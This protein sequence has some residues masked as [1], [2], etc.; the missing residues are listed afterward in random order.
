MLE[1]F[2][3][4]LQRRLKEETEKQ[5]NLNPEINLSLNLVLGLISGNKNKVREITLLADKMA[6]TS[7]N[8]Q[9]KKLLEL[10][11]LVWESLE[12]GEIENQSYII[13]SLVSEIKGRKRVI[14]NLIL[15]YGALKLGDKEL[16]REYIN[17]AALK[18]DGRSNNV[19]ELVSLISLNINI[20]AGD[21]SKSD[22]DKLVEFSSSNN[23]IQGYANYLI[24]CLRRYKSFSE[25][26]S[27]RHLYLAMEVFSELKMIYPLALCQMELVQCSGID[28]S[29]SELL[30]ASAKKNL[31]FLDRN[32]EASY[33][34]FLEDK[35]NDVIREG[36][37]VGELVY[38]SNLM[39]QVKQD[40]LKAA[41]CDY[42]VLIMGSSGSGKEPTAHAIQQYSNRA[43]KPFIIVNCSAIARGLID[44]EIFGCV[45]GAFTGA[46]K[47][48]P[49]YIGASEGGTLF[50]DEIAELPKE[51]QTK[52]LRLI[53]NGEYYPVGSSKVRKANVRIIAATNQPIKKLAE[54]DRMGCESSIRHELIARFTIKIYSPSLSE[55]R[56]DILPIA[57]EILRRE[58][59]SD[60][61]LSREA[62]SYLESRAYPLGVRELR[63]LLRNA[64]LSA[65]QQGDVVISKKH[66][67]SEE[68]EIREGFNVFCPTYNYRNAMNVLERELLANILREAGN[69][70]TIAI[71]LSGLPRSTFYRN[72]RVHGLIK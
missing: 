69:D 18:D 53:E 71:E 64:C 16:A 17:V 45:K 8:R 57:Q 27:K 59:N 44:S 25:V 12:K 41:S 20:E 68:E 66:L 58:G 54:D 4:R 35:L 3:D 32:R 15:T 48:R 11:L 65:R 28:L 49:G 43:K 31:E 39:A 55:R 63:D 23:L 60:L 9:E 56:E 36:F 13:R 26:V 52:L 38:V 51:S 7:D 34:R 24:G 37:K 29:E 19:S 33:C 40:I 61:G 67:R 5:V 47:D 62:K 70:S 6:E 21:C 46:D 72:C 10:I 1:R 50:L 2:S 30:L 42:P 22:I 14:A